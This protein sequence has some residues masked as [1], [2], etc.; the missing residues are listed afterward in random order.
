[1]Y[2]YRIFV[3]M[4]LAILFLSGI[5]E[6]AEEETFGVPIPV[7]GI[8]PNEG[9]TIGVILAIVSEQEGRLRSIIAPVATTNDTL[10]Y[11]LDFNYF[12]FPTTDVSYQLY[13]SHTTENFWE[14]SIEYTHRHF[15]SDALFLSAKLSFEKRANPRFYGIG[16]GTSERNETNYTNR[17]VEGSATL[18]IEFLKYVYGSFSLLGRR[19]WLRSGTVEDIDNLEERFPNIEGIRGGYSLPVEIALEYD[20]RDSYI[21]PS[22]GIHA[23][24]FFRIADESMLSSFSYR[25]Y[26]AT[27]KCYLSFDEEGRFVTALRASVEYMEGEDIPFYE[28]STLG[29]GTTLRGFGD[30][31]FYDKHR[32]LFNAEERVRLFRWL[33]GEI[34]LD[35]EGAIFVDIGQVFPS[36]R[37]MDHRDFE[38]V[39]GGGVRMVVRSQIVA[40]V[41]IGFGSDGSAIFAGLHYPF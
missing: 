27:G 20:S 9:T 18:T 17:E 31:R 41:D 6:A 30:G 1:M 14:Y 21:T 32:L 34:L 33:V 35:I 29:G 19:S 25:R 23:R 22:T 10:G 26:G 38:V 40:K 12:G 37:T 13:F 28:L 2:R 36:F 8:D 5:I 7:I 15:L 3:G 24:I 39:V 16:P 4:A 11:S